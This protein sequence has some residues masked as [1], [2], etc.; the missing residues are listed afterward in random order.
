MEGASDGL[1]KSRFPC[2]VCTHH[3]NQFSLVHFKGDIV[4][5]GDATVS[6]FNLRDL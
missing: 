4:N 5:N 1:E 6:D 2:T 3:R